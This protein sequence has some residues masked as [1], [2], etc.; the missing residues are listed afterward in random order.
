MASPITPHGERNES[1][2][3][4]EVPFDSLPEPIIKDIVAI[5]GSESVADLHNFKK[6]SKFHG[7]LIDDNYVLKQV[8]FEKSR[9]IQWEPN[10]NALAFLKRCEASGNLE[11]LWSEGLRDFFHYP[12][13]NWEGREKL[14]IAAEGGYN[15]AKYVYGLI[16]LC[17]END[18]SRNEG[19]KHI[20][21][22]R[23]NKCMLYCRNQMQERAGYFW[24]YNGMLVRN[25]TLVCKTRPACGGWRLNNGA[26]V[27]LKEEDDDLSSCE[28]CRCDEEMNHFYGMFRIPFIG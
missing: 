5:V 20:R 14:K 12:I 25:Q 24:R 13:G 23:M 2:E 22:L 19:I 16:M 3:A 6:T 9:K 17:S 4:T 7:Q 11:V 15:M 10:E 28:Y 26:W 8:S 18:E 1:N 21:D 27:L